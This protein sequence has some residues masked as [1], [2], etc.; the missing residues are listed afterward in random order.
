MATP[1]LH[2]VLIPFA[3]HL[4]LEVVQMKGGQ[5]ELRFEPKPEHMNSF[6]VAHGGALM[7]LLD[8]TM[9]GAARSDEPDLGVV[10]VEMKTLFMQPGRGV[11]TGRGRLMHRTKTMAFVEATAYDAE[12]RACAHASG[13]FK[14]VRRRSPAAQV[15]TD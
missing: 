14:Y 9:A 10:T 1:Q 6:E 3:E 15:S 8:V 11:L 5:A 7:T 13:T 2:G 4:G 12:G